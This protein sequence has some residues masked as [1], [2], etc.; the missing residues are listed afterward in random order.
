[1]SVKKIKYLA[2]SSEYNS[3][4]AEQEWKAKNKNKE[5]YSR[6]SE[7]VHARKRMEK[8]C[9]NVRKSCYVSDY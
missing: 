3:E 7:I 6:L 5:K 4:W 2:L 9:A 1:M 8:N